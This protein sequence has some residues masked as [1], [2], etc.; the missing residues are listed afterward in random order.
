MRLVI[1]KLYQFIDRTND[2]FFYLLSDLDTLY[3]NMYYTP[4]K[5]NILLFSNSF[6]LLEIVKPCKSDKRNRS[7]KV[8]SSQGSFGWFRI[9]QDR[10]EELLDE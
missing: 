3:T 8:L 9:N 10:L 5:K 7:I 1:G 2:G 6:I 4:D